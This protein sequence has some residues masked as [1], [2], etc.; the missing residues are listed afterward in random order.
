MTLFSHY[1]LQNNE[2]TRRQI[3]YVQASLA[4]YFNL[5]LTIDEVDLLD[6]HIYNELLNE[7][8][9]NRGGNSSG[10]YTNVNQLVGAINQ[11]KGK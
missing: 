3:L 2:I 11:I 10:N 5:S 8:L 1:I 4:R 6:Y 7:E 9:S